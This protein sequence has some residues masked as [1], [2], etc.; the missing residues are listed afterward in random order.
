MG[1]SE[2]DLMTK[3]ASGNRLVRIAE[4][5]LG[6]LLAEAFRSAVDAD[7]G[8]INGGSLRADILTGEIT[9]NDLLN[10][11]PFNNTIVL[12]EVNGQTI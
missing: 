7:I 9:F 11:L 8:Y 6:D 10:V 4:T 2:V 12:A 5:N 3:D 1:V